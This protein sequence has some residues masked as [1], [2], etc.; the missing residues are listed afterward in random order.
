MAANRLQVLTTESSSRARE[1]D[2]IR[3][4]VE[5]LTELDPKSGEDVELSELAERLTHLEELRIAASAPH[6]VLSSDSFDDSSDA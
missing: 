3:A 4:A 2:E 5:E 1:A 6:E